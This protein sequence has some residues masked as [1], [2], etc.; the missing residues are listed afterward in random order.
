MQCLVTD[1][2]ESRGGGGFKVAPRCH[3][4]NYDLRTMIDDEK[5]MRSIVVQLEAYVV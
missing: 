1:E 5:K 4:L 2:N 3:E